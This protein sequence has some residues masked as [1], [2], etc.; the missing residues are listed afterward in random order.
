MSRSEAWGVG[1]GIILLN[2]Q[3]NELF[4]RDGDKG[5]RGRNSFFPFPPCPNVV[6][7]RS[8]APTQKT[9]NAVDRRQNNTNVKAV[10]ARHCAATSV[11]TTQSLS[12]LLCGTESQ[13]QCPYLCCQE[14]TDA[15]EVQPSS[16]VPPPYS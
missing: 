1:M 7:V 16:P 13:R 10:S 12:Q 2:V 3:R 11:R 14:T 8:Q 9:K 6:N 5:G 4:I 15:K